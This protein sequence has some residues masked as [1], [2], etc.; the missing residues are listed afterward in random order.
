MGFSVSAT[1]AIFFAAFLLFFLM[2]YEAV[3]ESYQVIS[4]DLDAKYDTVYENTQIDFELIEISYDKEADV[5]SIQVK[6]TGSI[7]LD[8]NET[9]ILIGGTM[10]SSDS[11][12][13]R[14]IGS[15]SEKYWHPNVVVELNISSPNIS[16]VSS[17]AD[18]RAFDTDTNLESPGNLSVSDQIFV[19]DGTSVDV[20]NLDCTYK[21]TISDS[22][23]LILP[24][25]VK[26]QGDYVYLLDQYTHIDRFSK[27]GAWV[28][29]IVDDPTN[30]TNP[31]A[32]AVDSD[33]FYIVDNNDHIDRFT[34]AGAFVDALIANGGELSA[35]QDIYVSDGI[36]IIDYSGGSYHVDRYD[37]DGTGGAQLIGSA[38]IANPRDISV[39]D[40][41]LSVR[42]IYISNNTQEISVF[43]SDGDPVETIDTGLSTSV[44]GVDVAGRIYVSDESNGL[45]CEY[46]GMSIKLVLDRG[47]AIMVQL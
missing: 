22:V 45:I 38:Q 18:R 6:N 2:I 16:Y 25:D 3:D 8:M 41:D 33:Y 13:A 35:P 21:R 26:A 27:P 1:M 34:L 5:L 20:F 40:S 37:L 10:I 23:N 46:L 4:D 43:D 36:Y 47:Y 24:S 7:S 42:H 9:E 29:K 12:T 31:R 14:P 44:R 17:I 11:V 30:L 19:I 15:T 32:F 39:A 28:D